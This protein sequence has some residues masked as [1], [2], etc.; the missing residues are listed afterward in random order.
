M[1][2]E[3]LPSNQETPHSLTHRHARR[4]DR[5]V[6]ED[7]PNP[8]FGHN[9]LARSAQLAHS[10]QPVRAIARQG[11]WPGLLRRV[12]ADYDVLQEHAIAIEPARANIPLVSSLALPRPDHQITFP[13]PRYVG[14]SLRWDVGTYLEAGSK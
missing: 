11:G 4:I 7:S 13:I 10:H 2:A 14:K 6:I 9:R 5:C 12:L 3:I 8:Q 1:V